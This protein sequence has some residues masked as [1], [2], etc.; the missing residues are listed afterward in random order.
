MERR[1]RPPLSVHLSGGRKLSLNH[2]VG[3]RL[4]VDSDV[5][6]VVMLSRKKVRSTIE[7]QVDDVNGIAA[8]QEVGS[9]S[10]GMVGFVEPNLR[11]C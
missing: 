3:D 4:G 1:S 10:W 2:F 8:V 6:Q 5:S 9:P 11:S 7:R